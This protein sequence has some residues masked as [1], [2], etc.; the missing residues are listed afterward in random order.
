MQ[1]GVWPG[2]GLGELWQTLHH[3]CISSQNTLP[4]FRLFFWK[5]NLWVFG[6]NGA[7][8]PEHPWR[9]SPV[10]CV[11]VKDPKPDHVR[12]SY[13]P[14]CAQLPFD[15]FGWVLRLRSIHIW[16]TI[17]LGIPLGLGIQALTPQWETLHVFWL[18]QARVELT[19]VA[20]GSDW[21]GLS[22]TCVHWE[23]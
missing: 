7:C 18:W 3:R 16:F 8:E 21:F 15:H 12:G 5:Q 10:N 17:N 20:V 14:S 23:K 6:M 9:Q 2:A 11:R 22:L 4:L 19:L 13:F 1:Q